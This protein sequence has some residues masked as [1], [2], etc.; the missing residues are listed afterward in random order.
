[1]GGYVGGST[2][3]K[4]KGKKGWKEGLWEEVIRRMDSEGYVK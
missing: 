4:E 2:L 3:S 1:V